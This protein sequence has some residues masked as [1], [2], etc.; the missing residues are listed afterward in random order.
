M[1]RRN[2]QMVGRLSRET[3]VRY[4][5][6][7]A[8][9]TSVLIVALIVLF[10]GREA[11]PFLLEPGGR[12]LW[13]TRWVPV[14]L[15]Q[16]SYG[17]LPLVAGT[18]LVTLIAMAITVPLGVCVAVYI[19]EIARPWERAVLKPLMEV[20]AAVPSVVLGFFG[21]VVLSP[22]ITRLFG[23]P[24]GLTALTGSLLLAL[25]AIPTVVA[26]AEEAI[27][28][29]PRSLTYASLALGATPLRTLW[30]VTVPAAGPGIVA[31]VLLG[32]GRVVGETMAVLM[33]TGNAAA[34]TFSPLQ[35]VRTMTATIALEMGEVAFGSHHYRALFCLGVLLLGITFALNVVARGTLK[36]QMRVK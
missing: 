18:L 1:W 22:W 29:V 33:V 11:G 21:L 23:L 35:S 31:A 4:A 32:T 5:R 10:L 19:A 7:L 24:T 25:M 9:S 27:R 26:I 17:I 36:R 8:A 28:S 15:Q 13:G 20:L 16:E 14:S 34:I 12:E 6:L 2:K 30:R 3:W